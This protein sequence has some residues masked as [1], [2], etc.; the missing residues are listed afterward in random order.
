MAIVGFGQSE[1]V[2][3]E[4]SWRMVSL[5]CLSEE[6]LNRYLGKYIW[7]SGKEVWVGDNNLV[8]TGIYM[9]WKAMIPDGA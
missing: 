1:G 4:F 3:E 6:T 5:K 8:V 9:A 2:K 7:S